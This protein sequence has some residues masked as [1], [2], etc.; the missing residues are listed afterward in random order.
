M[1]QVGGIELLCIAGD[2]AHSIADVIAETEFL[3]QRSGDRVHRAQVEGLAAPGAE[4]GHACKS[5]NG[6]SRRA[7]KSSIF[8]RSFQLT[9]H[10]GVSSQS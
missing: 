8:M 6:S 10:R 1:C 2:V 3:V 9:L 7:V 4:V 5:V